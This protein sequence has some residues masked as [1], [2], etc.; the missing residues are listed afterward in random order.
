MIVLTLFL[1]ACLGNKKSVGIP[2]S[3][4]HDALTGIKVGPAQLNEK[5]EKVHNIFNFDT[6]ERRVNVTT[7]CY[8][9]TGKMINNSDSYAMVLPPQSISGWKP[10]CPK[11]TARYSIV[12]KNVTQG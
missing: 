1:T 3:A 9:E 4:T 2:K 10:T 11:N 6:F 7:F 8:D 5:K 12:I